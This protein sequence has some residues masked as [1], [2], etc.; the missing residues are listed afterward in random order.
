MTPE[1]W[2]VITTLA[3]MFGALTIG[4]YPADLVMVAA[5]VALVTIDHLFPGLTVF[6]TQSSAFASFANEGLLTVAALFVVAAGLR[7]TGALDRCC[8]L[9]LGRSSNVLVGQIRLVLPVA[10]A[11]AFVNNTP[12]VAVMLPLV[13]AWARRCAIAPSRLMM[14]LS[15]ATI[16]GGLC[17]TLGTST[18]VV[19]YGLLLDATGERLGLFDIGKVGL[20]CAIGGLAYILLLGRRMLPDRTD[21]VDVC[22]D[23]RQYSAELI[24]EPGSAVAGK[25]ISAAGLRGMPDVY[26]AEIVRD[27]EVFAAVEPETRLQVGDR[28]VFVGVVS[29][30]AELRRIKGLRPATQPV[31]A[32]ADSSHRRLF[33]AVVSDSCRLLGSKIRDGHFRSVYNA[34]VLAVARGGRR[35]E[36]RIGDIELRPGDTLLLEASSGFAETQ[37]YS[38]DFFL[39]SSAGD[40]PSPRYDRSLVAIIILVSMIVFAASGIITMLN[41][42]LLAAGA[43]VASRCLGATLARRSIDWSVLIVIGAGLSLGKAL[44]ESGAA[45]TIVD[46]VLSITGTNPIVCVATIYGL[47]MIFTEVLS[48]NAAAALMFPIAMRTAEQIGSDHLAFVF[49]IMIAASCGFATP[50]GY[51]TNLMVYGPGGYRFSDFLRFGGALNLLIWVVAVSAITVAFGL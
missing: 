42:A 13:S 30:V 50:I 35:V 45:R 4:R 43:M 18:N 29:A 17:T 49:A 32:S 8:T 20:P 31:D 22:T 48:N 28:L 38:R 2:I 41:A 16:L 37:R 51:Q 34:A 47:T 27:D 12:L 46:A 14:P 10:A 33:E 7:E 23:P 26:L 44:E 39:V 24:V 11:S 25:S 5:L 15:F 1:G 40:L 9:I 3:V 21:P 6:A 36:G 19:V